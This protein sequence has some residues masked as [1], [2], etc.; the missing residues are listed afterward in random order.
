MRS[1]T[2]SALTNRYPDSDGTHT[3]DVMENQYQNPDFWCP[4]DH[5]IF[6]NNEVSGAEAF[7]VRM[8]LLFELLK[9]HVVGEVDTPRPVL[10]AYKADA[11]LHILGF[12]AGL[13]VVRD[14][15][16]ADE[17]DARWAEW[18][19]G[20]RACADLRVFDPTVG[21]PSSTP[22]PAC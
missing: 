14:R 1:A 9:S 7:S 5:P 20:R 11:S 12:A 17:V 13:P 6:E 4:V 15:L 2:C 22:S 10:S 3:N 19:R 21:V 16:L 8:F 18:L